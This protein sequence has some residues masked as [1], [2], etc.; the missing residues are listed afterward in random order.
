[1]RACILVPWGILQKLLEFAGAG[2]LVFQNEWPD[3]TFWGSCLHSA[4]AA[5]ITGPDEH[6]EA[7]REREEEI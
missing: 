6:E 5:A 1:M 7:D 3:V 2:I 4:A